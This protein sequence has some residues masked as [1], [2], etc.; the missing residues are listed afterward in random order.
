MLV[1]GSATSRAATLIVSAPPTSLNLS[2]D[3]TT[4]GIAAQNLVPNQPTLDARPLLR[5]ALDYAQVHHV[6]II[7]VDKGNYYVLSADGRDRFLNIYH[8][9][10]LTIDL[11]GSTIFF[12]VGFLQGFAVSD[13]TRVTLA[14]FSIDWLHPPYT[15]AELTSVDP[16]TRTISYRPLAGWVDPIT[17]K[18]ATSPYGPL[19]HFVALFRDG[20]FVPG[21]TRTHI[22][23]PSRPGVL[24]VDDPAPWAQSRTLATLRPGDTIVLA[25]RGGG[26]PI[27]VFRGD[28]VVVANVSVFG[29]GNWA[30]A[31]DQVSNSTAD[32]VR[33]MPR[34]GTGLLGSNAD[35]IHFSSARQGN[36]IRYCFVTRTLDDG[37][38]IDSMYVATVL[39][40]TGLRRLTVQRSGYLRFA[41]GTPVNFV[42]SASTAEIAGGM[43]VSQTPADSPSPGF[44]ETVDLMFDRDLPPLVAGAG[45]V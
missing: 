21:T 38:A 6:S 24:T 31:F 28:A 18:D 1:V 45:M 37:I 19:D 3:L 7:T 14:N 20:A 35:G 40:K 36:L 17:F 39:A 33:I 27:E 32:R 22:Q 5:A 11:A 2:H 29:S 25:P 15:H 4:F 10:D 41:N 12:N 23:P 30:V 13:C 16:L 34:P 42:D 26:P 9:S 43:V 8:M 44:N